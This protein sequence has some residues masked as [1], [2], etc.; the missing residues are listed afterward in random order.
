MRYSAEI[1]GGRPDAHCRMHGDKCKGDR[2]LWKGTVGL[3]TLWLSKADTTTPEEHERL[4]V[5]LAE[6]HLPARIEA[7]DSFKATAESCRDP[8]K[9]AVMHAILKQERDP[10]F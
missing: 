6:S 1:A 7:R 3:Q 4:K 10:R 2:V 9:K 8:I 5:E